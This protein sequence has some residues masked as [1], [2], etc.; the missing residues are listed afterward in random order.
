[1]IKSTI[2]TLI[3]R[4]ISLVLIVF[5]ELILAQQ[6]ES[7]IAHLRNNNL[8]TELEVY[9]NQSRMEDSVMHYQYAK[10][11]LNPFKDSLFMTSYLRSF[12]MA[13]RDSTFMRMAGLA[14]L[15]KANDQLLSDWF[16][17]NKSK[18]QPN[19]NTDLNGI[20]LA[21]KDPAR[22]DASQ[23]PEPLQT[24][25]LKYKSFNKKKA[26]TAAALSCL[27]PGIGKWYAGKPGS[28]L[29][30]FALC[31]A[32]FFQTL[33]SSKKL[34]NTHPLT[35]INLSGFGIFYLSGI[36][37]SPKAVKDKK[38]ELKKQFLLDAVYYYH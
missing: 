6:D 23:F 2:A 9:L 29:M 21:S 17:E 12:Q 10:F 16:D 37:G 25:F 20:Y 26:G 7:F 27:I 4:S 33:E 3:K 5:S 14:V 22:F 19:F 11:Y 18:T 15:E 31:S 30:S 24:S 35:I 1:M 32:Y 38:R 13:N 28:F 8:R 36:Y 34:G